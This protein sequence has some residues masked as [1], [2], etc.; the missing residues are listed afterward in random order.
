METLDGR[1]HTLEA[2]EPWT[3]GRTG[4]EVT[5]ELGTVDGTETLGPRARTVEL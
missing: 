4:P 2:V 3:V 1:A 5:V